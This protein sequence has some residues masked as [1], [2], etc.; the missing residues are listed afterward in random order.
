MDIDNSDSRRYHPDTAR[1]FAAGRL[2]AVMYADAVVTGAN[3]LAYLAAAGL[4]SRLL[5][6]SPAV[7]VG[8]GAFL[9]GYAVVVALIG[10]RRPIS[11]A[12]VR[13]AAVV[14]LVWVIGSIAVAAIPAVDLTGWGRGWAVLQ[15][16]VVLGFAVLQITGIRRR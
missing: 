2:R 7:L 16:L 4:L 14:N 13:G 6:P 10:R 11:P 5:G 15:A 8:I 9:L 12:A 1:S 3:G